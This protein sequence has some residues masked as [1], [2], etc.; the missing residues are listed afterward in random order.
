[1]DVTL[2]RHETSVGVELGELVLIAAHRWDVVGAR[3][4]GLQAVW[5]DRLEKRWPFPLDE[6]PRAAG[7]VEAAELA[8][9]G[10]A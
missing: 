8:L 5:I 7:S 1:V 2:A 9:A 6:P 4:A 3:A 10:I